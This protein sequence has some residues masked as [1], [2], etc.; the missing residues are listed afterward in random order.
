MYLP[1]HI[2]DWIA[3]DETVLDILYETVPILEKRLK[4]KKPFHNLDSNKLISGFILTG[5]KNEPPLAIFSDGI[6]NLDKKQPTTGSNKVIVDVIQL[7]DFKSIYDELSDIAL[8]KEKSSKVI[9][10]GLQMIHQGN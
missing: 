2:G 8:K 4:E 7:K 6:A 10:T 9:L 5:F 3:A 1:N